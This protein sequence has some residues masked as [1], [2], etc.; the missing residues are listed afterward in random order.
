VELLIFLIETWY[1]PTDARQYNLPAISEV[2]LVMTD[3]DTS[4]GTERDMVREYHGGA[5]KRLRNPHRCYFPLQYPLIHLKGEDGWHSNI[6][7][8]GNQITE[9][10]KHVNTGNNQ[11]V[12][13]VQRGC[14]RST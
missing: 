13:G 8:A 2:A 9:D 11:D 5:L 7:L 3:G 12:G 6:S 14:G 1:I 10:A 4:S